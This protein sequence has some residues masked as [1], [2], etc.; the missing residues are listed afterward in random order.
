MYRKLFKNDLKHN[1]LPFVSIAFFIALSA[2]LLSSAGYL[3]VQLARSIEQL[4]EEAK[5]PHILQMHK[6]EID[7]PRM[8]AFVASHPEIADF[9]ILPFLNIDNNLLQVNGNSLQDS[10]YDNGF[11]TQSERFDFLFD[12][13]GEQ[14][15]ARPGE[16]YAPVFYLSSGLMKEGDCLQIASK[17]LIVSGFVRDSQMNAS[18]SVSKR[19]VISR[20]DFLDLAPHG[21][22]ESLI[23]FRLHDTEKISYIENEYAKHNLESNGPLS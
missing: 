18:L 22:L 13:E 19:F 10:V 8:G 17:N 1:L 5:T 2:A 4:F 14:I 3:G 6:G 21:E 20:E 15:Q 9:Q 23:E 16:V 7:L 12:L 11:S